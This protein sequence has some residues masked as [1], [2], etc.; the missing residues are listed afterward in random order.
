[1]AKLIKATIKLNDTSDSLKVKKSNPDLPE[2]FE[3]VLSVLNNGVPI[4]DST[5]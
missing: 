1:M 5:N 2:M 4:L 3:V